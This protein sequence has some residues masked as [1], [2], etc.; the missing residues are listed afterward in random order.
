MCKKALV[1]MHRRSKDYNVSLQD[2]KTVYRRPIKKTPK[3]PT[4]MENP[5]LENIRDY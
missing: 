2:V 5:Q 4:F 3:L 1:V